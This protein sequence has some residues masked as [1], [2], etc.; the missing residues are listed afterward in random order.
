MSDTRYAISDTRY[1][2][3]EALVL[4]TLLALATVIRIP[5]LWEPIGSDQAI[6]AV[7]GE[8]LRRGWVLYR[9]IWDQHTPLVYY[10]HAAGQVLF[11]RTTRTVYLLDLLWTLA[12]ALALYGLGRRWQGR[13][14]A[15]LAT[16]LYVLFGN[17]VAFNQDTVGT[18]TMRV[19][20]EG[21]MTLPLALGFQAVLRAMD[22]GERWPSLRWG[23]AGLALGFAVALKPVAGL[24]LLLVWPVLLVATGRRSGNRL[25][26]ATQH[27]L[28]LGGGFLLAQL[29]YLIPTAVQGTLRDFWQAVVL[30]NLGPY[31]EIGQSRARF[32]EVSVLIGK[33]TFGLWLLAAAGVL[34]MLWRERSLGN[35]LIVGWGLARGLILVI[36]NKFYSYQ[37]LPLLPPL[38]LLAAYGVVYLWHWAGRWRVGGLP[39]PLGEGRGEGLVAWAWRVFLMFLL[40]ANV[41][42]FVRTNG[43][44][45]SRFLQFASG[46][47]DADAFYA[48]FNTYPRHYSYPA[49]KAVADWVRERTRPDEPLGTLGGYG[50]TPI[51]LAERPPAARYVFTYPFFHQQV[52]DD[53]LI[54]EM[55][56][57]LL[58]DLQASRP[59]YIVLF[60][61]LEEFKPFGP[62]YAW[63]TANYELE[64]E[65]A[66]GRI[67]YRRRR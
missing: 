14:V 26:L 22:P 2:T 44:Y 35:W 10:I 58:A 46:S 41:A 17:S 38:C 12:S 57:E 55:R 53:P 51:W 39:L 3:G 24:F 45:Y 20:A 1:A 65:F 27:S 36:Q 43:L 23:L 16:G 29:V 49:D 33:E 56:A 5:S 25:A 13:Q 54:Q 47:M 7:I 42:Q 50:A 60:D 64:R 9:D 31:S 66:H 4:L 18:W 62:L 15:L 21:L 32:L 8:A 28:W 40:L 30:Y 52:A 63:L 59:P 48:A 6:G 67:L 37:Y 19:K 34:W 61:P 11:G